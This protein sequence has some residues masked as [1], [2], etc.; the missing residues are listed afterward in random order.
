MAA[1]WRNKMKIKGAIF[2]MDGTLADSMVFWDELWGLI[3]NAYCDGKPFRP[4]AE[5]EEKMRTMTTMDVCALLHRDYGM[6]KSPEEIYGVYADAL[7]DFYA[8]TVQPKAGAAE[9]LEYLSSQG[10]SMCIASGSAANLVELFLNRTGLCKYFGKV[11]SCVDIG[12]GKDKPDI[13]LAALDFLG[14]AKEDTWVFEDAYIAVHTA[15]ELGLN[16]V[17]IYDAQNFGQDKIEKEAD[18]YIAE[19]ETLE[20]LIK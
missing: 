8:S 6:G 2:D 12:A 15:K 19:G 9:F 4:K 1:E 20:K 16:V 5:D 17:G 13:Y 10:V 18:I 3:G 14:T 7:V 11:F